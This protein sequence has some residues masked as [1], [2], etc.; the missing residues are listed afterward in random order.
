MSELEILAG[1]INNFMGVA[2]NLAGAI[3]IVTI[4]TAMYFFVKIYI[5]VV[6]EEIQKWCRKVRQR[7]TE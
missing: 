7:G 6:K 1:H 2:N 3:I 5:R 4:L